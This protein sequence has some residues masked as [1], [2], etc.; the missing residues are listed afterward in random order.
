[1][2]RSRERLYISR[3][4]RGQV[5]REKWRACLG[6][7]VNFSIGKALDFSSCLFKDWM[8]TLM[9]KQKKCFART[10]THT[11]HDM[12]WHVHTT[13]TS[14]MRPRPIQ[15]ETYRI[16]PLCTHFH[17]NTV[18]YFSFLEKVAPL[19]SMMRTAPT[20]A[21]LT[22]AIE[23]EKVKASQT[24]GDGSFKLSY[25]K[26]SL[27]IMWSMSGETSMNA[28][29]LCQHRSYRPQWANNKSRLG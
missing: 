28:W 18:S 17:A 21:F 29:C 4:N 14:R 22:D 25:V 19:V 24:Y 1:M 7:I 20:D 6:E 23:F 11:V 16:M 2:L 26:M 10:W 13:S 5:D 27:I 3:Q 9:C 12:T 8:L 15:I